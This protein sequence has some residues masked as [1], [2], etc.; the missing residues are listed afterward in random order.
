M[1]V[2]IIKLDCSKLCFFVQ[3]LAQKPFPSYVF[4][5]HLNTL[6]VLICVYRNYITSVTSMLCYK[7]SIMLI[8]VKQTCGNKNYDSTSRPNNYV[9]EISCRSKLWDWTKSRPYKMLS[10]FFFV[11]QNEKPCAYKWSS[12]KFWPSGEDW[13]VNTCSPRKGTA[14]YR[15][16][17]QT[18]KHHDDFTASFGK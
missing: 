12:L 17:Q 10:Q 1:N 15:R 3:F 16:C 4:I 13:I 18:E 9:N 5:V 2:D 7:K 6:N 11:L 8:I 14:S